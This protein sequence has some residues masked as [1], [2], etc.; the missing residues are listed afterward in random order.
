MSIYLRRDARDLLAKTLQSLPISSRVLGPPKGYY[1]SFDEYTRAASDQLARRWPVFP[2]ESCLFKVPSSA[3]AKE[4]RI[5]QPLRHESPGFELYRIQNG[6]F[7][8][9]ATAILTKDDRLLAP[10]SAWM[11]EGPKDN[12]L[13]RKIRLGSLRRFSGKSLL[14]GGTRNYYHFLIEEIPRLWLARQA[15]FKIDDFDHLIMF[16]PM[17]DSQHSLILSGPS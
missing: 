4:I 15:G 7:H 16:S 10:F 6:R 8:R 14:I 17:H 1:S 2:P 12:W 9:D 13:F 11:G 3:G 5:F